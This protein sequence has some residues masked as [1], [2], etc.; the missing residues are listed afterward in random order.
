MTDDVTVEWVNRA[1]VDTM[2][3][4]ITADLEA[5][6]DPITA[7]LRAVVVPAA[8]AAAPHAT[9]RL[10]GS[11]DAGRGGD[12]LTGRVTNA[13]PYARMVHDGT[14]YVPARPWLVQTVDATAPQWTDAVT[15]ALQAD[16]DERAART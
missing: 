8:A 1:A 15:A 13:A 10:A 6:G 16:L 11:H 4:G 7:A 14:R 2:F 9:G 12:K 5:L 3:A